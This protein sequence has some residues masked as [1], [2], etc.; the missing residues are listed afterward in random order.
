MGLSPWPHTI[1]QCNHLN[2]T[3][4]LLGINTMKTRLS[5]HAGFLREWSTSPV[6]YYNVSTLEHVIVV[7]VGKGQVV[8]GG[9]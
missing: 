9:Q 4:A 1:A 7:V 8:V 3:T 2:S 6:Y 5:V